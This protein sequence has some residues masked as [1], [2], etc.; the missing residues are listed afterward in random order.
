MRIVFM[1]LA[2]LMILGCSSS[3]RAIGTVSSN[4][5]DKV[6]YWQVADGD[7]ERLLTRAQFEKLVIGK[8]KDDVIKSIGEPSSRAA[9]TWEYP[10]TTWQ[11]FDKI[12]SR[13]I[14]TWENGKVVRVDYKSSPQP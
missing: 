9:D 6:N 8:S 11:A 12:D 10:N 1:L 3:K 14:V 13:T 5:K 4:V 7:V 2:T